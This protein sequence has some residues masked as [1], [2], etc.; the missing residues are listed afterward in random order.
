[1]TIDSMTAGMSEALHR[2]FNKDLPA[3]S[4]SKLDEL[5]GKCGD[6]EAAAWRILMAYQ[7]GAK[8]GIEQV[9]KI[10]AGVKSA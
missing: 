7:M 6:D 4:R 9:N 10:Y 3:E 8:D 1:V 5:L 2:L